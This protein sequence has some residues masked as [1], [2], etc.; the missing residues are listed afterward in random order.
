MKKNE[1]NQENN[2]IKTFLK[3]I[4]QRVKLNRMHGQTFGE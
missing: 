4:N 3:L 2:V 1:V